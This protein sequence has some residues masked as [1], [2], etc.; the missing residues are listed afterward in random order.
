MTSAL[1]LLLSCTMQPAPSAAT[2]SGGM[3]QGVSI[4]ETPFRTT[5]TA[6]IVDAKVNGK[7]L[8]FMF[9]TGFGGYVV[10]DSGINLGKADQKMSLK[11]FVG[12]LEV[13]AVKI[14][15]LYLGEEKIPVEDTALAVMQPGA[16]NSL[17]YGMHCDGIMGLS[18]IKN[19]ITEINFENKKFRFYP[20]SYDITKK[21]P[22]NK[23]TF[24]A[25]LLPSG[26]NSLEMLVKT[27]TGSMVLAL[28]TGNSFYATTHKEVLDRLGIWPISKKPDFMTISGVASGTVDSFSIKMPDV[29]IFGVPVEAPIFDIID[30]P[31][32]D[33]DGDGTIGFGFL[34]NFNITIDYARRRVWLENFTGKVKDEEPGDAGVRCAWDAKSKYWRVVQAVNK[35]PAAEAG[36]K[37]GDN[38]L[39]IDGVEQGNMGFERLNNQF[40]GR[41]DSEVQLTLS[42]KGDLYKATLKRKPLFNL[43]QLK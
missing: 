30:L 20:N 34:K 28:D 9:D 27:K 18:V 29:T 38:L 32:S 1:A 31:K 14:K 16:D 3:A 7:N 10:C 22:D 5:E 2:P 6:M 43:S 8:S 36:I 37:V 13:D 4:V 26:F 17:N 23:K 11:D 12:V 15:S 40:K 42:R 21:V 35:G 25:K 41:I 19:T 33:A 24:L 39:A